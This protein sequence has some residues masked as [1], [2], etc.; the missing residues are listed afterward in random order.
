M[1]LATDILNR[2]PDLSPPSPRK[3]NATYVQLAKKKEREKEKL[4]A[5]VHKE[6]YV[7]RVWYRAS[8]RRNKTA[9]HLGR[10]TTAARASLAYKLFCLWER[11]GFED[12]PNKPS[13]RL[14]CFAD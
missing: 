6:D 3:C 7:N 13:K 12:V 5:G 1:S 4:P 8:I 10:F 2:K 14:Y 11:R 9:R